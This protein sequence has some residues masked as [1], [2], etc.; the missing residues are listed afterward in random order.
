[1]LDPAVKKKL[2]SL[3]RLPAIPY[4]MSQVMQALDN[5]DISA[6][7]L[8][9]VIEK[10]QALTGRVLTVANSPFYGF[11]RRISTIDLAIVVLGTNAI[12]EIVISLLVS[13]FFI[14]RVN[15]FD[16]KGF[17]HYSVFC[18]ACARVLARKLGYRLAGEAFVA[19]L[20]H[21]I[22]I[23]ILTQYF[24][25]EY[26]KIV[27]IQS[28][29]NLPMV[30]AEKK[31]LRGT[32]GDLGVWIAERWN[33]PGQLC[34]AILYH[35]A[36]YLE[37]KKLEQ[38]THRPTSETIIEGVEQPLTLITAMTEWFAAE[39][40]FKGWTLEEKPSPLYLAVETLEDIKSHDILSPESAVEMLK[41]E[42]AEEYEK[43]SAIQAMQEKP[44][45]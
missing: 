40:G 37:V 24:S 13:K 38:K 31:V 45:Y 7:A 28:K 19:G 27:S 43:A 14:K 26:A 1:M 32:H 30:E 44:L 36:S 25:R 10:D 2:E 11:A 42:I 12:R 21:D 8:A 23:V 35:H 29:Y 22:G 33:L 20:M 5:P 3:T 39:M 17:W 16:V 15:N 6:P 18:G 41:R 34:D 4:V 9:A